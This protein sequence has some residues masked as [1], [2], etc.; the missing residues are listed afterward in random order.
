MNCMAHHKYNH[1]NQK[2]QTRLI[3]LGNDAVFV[4]QKV[5]VRNMDVRYVSEPDP[6]HQALME[7]Y[8]SVS[9][10]TPHNDFDNH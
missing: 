8:V 6:M 7:M 2:G 5:C 4:T 1:I 3:E 10:E 9:L